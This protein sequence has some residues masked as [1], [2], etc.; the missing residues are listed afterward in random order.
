[1]R[2]GLDISQIV[3]QG[4][5]VA[6]FTQGL[7][8]TILK[9]DQK[10]HWIFFFSGLRQKLPHK[11]EDEIK[12]KNHQLIKLPFP[13]TLLS[14]FFNKLHNA[15]KLCTFNLPRRQAGFSLLTS[16]DWFITSDWTEPPLPINKTTIVHDLTYLRYPETV[17]KKILETQ[18]K[19]LNWVRKE[20]KIIFADSET[21]KKDLVKFLQINKNK[22]FVNYPGVEVEMPSSQQ[23]NQT[24][25]KYHLEKPFILTVGKLEPRKNLKRLIEAMKQCNNKTIE[26]VIVGPRGWE[27][28]NDIT[29]A[30]AMKQSNNIRFLGYVDDTD[31]YALYSACLFFIYPS[32]WEG[33]GYPLVEAMKIGAPIACSRISPF[34][35]IAQKNAI[36]FNPRSIEEMTHCI[37]TMIQD[38]GLRKN[39]AEG[40]KIRAKEFSWKKYYD[41]LTETLNLNI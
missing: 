1:M 4:T 40:G 27:Q 20:S 38:D 8:D 10:N 15:S 13:P 6:R 2:I 19:R 3:Y 14:L 17:A 18:Q 41:F 39:L 31:L 28:F 34:E 36:Y 30:N 9:Y 35:E 11:Y 22:I 29:A 21:T 5:G 33:F 23:I 26:L 25:K 32:L 12:K 37:E 24:L 7:V 16:L